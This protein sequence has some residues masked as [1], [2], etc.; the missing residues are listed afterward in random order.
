MENG[1]VSK[2][3]ASKIKQ[4]TLFNA[5]NREQQSADLRQFQGIKQQLRN[6]ISRL[7]KAGQTHYNGGKGPMD[8]QGADVLNIFEYYWQEMIRVGG[9]K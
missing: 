8:G 9:M 2:E 1:G 7:D 5:G 4:I 3:D 6:A